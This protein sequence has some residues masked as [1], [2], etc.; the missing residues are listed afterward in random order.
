MSTL[1]TR[2]DYMSR[3]GG[4]N[5]EDQNRALHRAYYKQFVNAST[6]AHVVRIIGKDRLLASTDEHLNDIPL[7]RWDLLCGRIP[8]AIS[9]RDVGQQGSSLSD[10]VCIAKEAARQWIESQNQA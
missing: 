8:L 5:T 6:I 10:W 7:G 9:F 1:I 2:D 4:D 3:Y